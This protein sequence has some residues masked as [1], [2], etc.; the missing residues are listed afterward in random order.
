MWTK[1]EVESWIF[2]K[3]EFVETV[4]IE[5]FRLLFGICIHPKKSLERIHNN[6]RISPFVFFVINLFV[7]GTLESFGNLKEFIDKLLKSLVLTTKPTFDEA[8]Y[9]MIGLLSGTLLFVFLFR[10]ISG[11]II[12]QKLSYSCITKPILYASFLYIPIVILNS[13]IASF[14][15]G[16]LLQLFGGNASM[17]SFLIITCILYIIILDGGHM[18]FIQD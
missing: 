8:F 7:A 9:S 11:R 16:Q 13:L 4:F 6:E 1:E 10:L 3:F 2:D 14:M 15:I 12:K 17:F 18:F 5:Y